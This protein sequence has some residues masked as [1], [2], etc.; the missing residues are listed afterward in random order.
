M[1]FKK[2]SFWGVSVTSKYKGFKNLS[3]D[4]ELGT[5]GMLEGVTSK[6]YVL[7]SGISLL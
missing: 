6:G 1:L 7:T 5:I 2:E 4:S 3:W